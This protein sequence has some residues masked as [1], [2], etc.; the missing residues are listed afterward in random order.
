MRE[1][2]YYHRVVRRYTTATARYG[3]YIIP[4]AKRGRERCKFEKI[5]IPLLSKHTCIHIQILSSCPFYLYCIIA[6]RRRGGFS[7]AF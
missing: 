5:P 2:N 3:C 1:M 7:V 4:R 6:E